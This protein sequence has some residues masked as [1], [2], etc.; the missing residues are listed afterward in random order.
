MILYPN[1]KINLGL[2]IVGKRTD[3]YHDIETLFLPI[4]LC[5]CLEITPAH[6]DSFVM[7]GRELDC[8]A[9]DNLVVRVLNML[10]A[11]DMDIPPVAIRLTKNIPS[12]AGLG[13]GSTDAA[14]MMKGL[15]ELFD[16]HLTDAQMAARVGRLGADCPVFIANKPVYAEGKGD[17]FTQLSVP[18]VQ[19]QYFAL[20]PVGS[21][22]PPSIS[23]SMPATLDGYWLVLVKPNDF[24]STREAYASVT[25]VPSQ[26]SL[27]DI[28]SQ[29]VK[30]WRGRMVNDFEASVFPTH[31][32]VSGIC[33]QLYMLGASYAAMSGSGSTVFGLFRQQPVL[34]DVFADHFQWQCRL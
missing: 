7:D 18:L 32:V 22:L 33:D 19:K 21:V 5:D 3:G 13:G 30:T 23:L 24:I 29:P 12:G 28:I 4:P 15:N 26:V 9:Q 27:N 10:R 16:L 34:G 17:I 25:P 1:C 31:P 20:P 14:F 6:E 2:N 8:S 11:E